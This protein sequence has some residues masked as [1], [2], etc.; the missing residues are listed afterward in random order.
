MVFSIQ[1]TVSAELK[2]YL[3]NCAEIVCAT[4]TD[5]KYDKSKFI[6]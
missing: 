3:P 6:H 4:A 2:K 1:Q 5:C